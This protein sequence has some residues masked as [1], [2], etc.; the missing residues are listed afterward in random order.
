MFHCETE[1]ID[2]LKEE[3]YWKKH[4]PR[5]ELIGFNQPIY[6]PISKEK[7]GLVDIVFKRKATGRHGQSHYKYF[8]EAKFDELNKSGDFW[9]SLKILGYVKAD[10]LYHFN[11][12][13]TPLVMLNKAILNYDYRVI[14]YTLKI[15]W[16]AFTINNDNINF[17]ISFADDFV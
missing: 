9:N 7:I 1:I 13:A 11:D 12:N 16:I 8:V 15:G 17:E 3:R 14:L 6:G 10:N 5:F 4:F 2:Y